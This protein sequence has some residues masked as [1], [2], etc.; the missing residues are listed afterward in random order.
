MTIC[1]SN[2]SSINFLLKLIEKISQDNLSDFTSNCV[3]NYLHLKNEYGYRTYGHNYIIEKL[4]SYFNYKD[5][6]LLYNDLANRILSTEK[7]FDYFYSISDDL[8][9]FSLYYYLQN[10]PDKIELMF[11]ERCDMHFSFISAAGSIEINHQKM[12]IDPTIKNIY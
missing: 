4:Y 11:K 6:I 5:W 7:D 3:I 2:H 9:I 12:N 8:E 1:N 10:Y